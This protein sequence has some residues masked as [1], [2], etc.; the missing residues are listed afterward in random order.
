MWDAKRLCL[1]LLMMICLSARAQFVD[2]FSDGDFTN[3]PEWFGQTDR[4][5]V[6]NGRLRLNAPAVAA[7]SYLTTNSQ[8]IENGVWEFFIRLDFNP[9][10]TNL[11]RVY[12]VADNPDLSQPLNG[13]FVRIGGTE[14]EVSLY[15]QTGSAITKIIDGEDKRIDF[16]LVEVKI[17]VTRDDEGNWELFSDVNASGNY[18]QEGLTIKD[19]THL[20]ST[21][22]G[23]SCIYTQTRSTHFYF[24]DFVVTGTPVTDKFPPEVTQ[25]E[26]VDENSLRII[27]N[28]E[29]EE[30]SATSTANYFLNEGLGIAQ[31]VSLEENNTQALVQFG[32]SFPNGKLLTLSING[33]ED[34]S[35][36]A[37]NNYQNTF[38][39]FVPEPAEWKD[40]IISEFFPDPDPPVGLP[41]QEFVEIYNRSNKVFNLLNWKLIDPGASGT[42][43]ELFFFPGDYLILASN[44]NAPL[45]DSYGQSMGITGMPILSNN[46]DILTLRDPEGNLIDSLSYDLTWYHDNS[47]RDGGWTIE[48]IDIDNFCTD[49]ENYRASADEAGGTP[50]KQNSV[51]DIIIDEAGPKLQQVVISDLNT[52]LLQFDERLSQPSLFAEVE[53]FPERNINERNFTTNIRNEIE[54]VLAEQLMYGNTYQVTVGNV[55]DCKTNSIDPEYGSIEIF[56]EADPPK[57]ISI[58]VLS[59]NELRL[60]FSEELDETSSMATENFI[61]SHNVG[62]PLYAGLSDDN[63]SIDL[64]FESSLINGKTYNII[65]NGVKG[66]FENEIDLIQESFLFFQ[67][68][69]ANKYDIIITELFPDP[70]PPVNLPEHEFVEIYNRSNHPFDLAGWKLV[71][72]GATGTLPAYLMQPG[73]YVILTSLSGVPKFEGFGKALGVPGMPILSNNSDQPSLVSPEG[74]TVDSV[75]YQL[76]WY[77]DNEKRDG[78][79][80]LERIDYENICNDADNWIASADASGGTPGK[81]NS[82]FTVSNN[83]VPPKMQHVLVDSREKINIKFDKKLKQKSLAGDIYIDPSVAINSRS[84]SSA[85]R[86]EIKLDLAE[87]LDWG[88]LYA[89]RVDNMFD[90]YNNTIDSNHAEVEFVALAPAPTI[91]DLI[92]VDANHLKLIFSEELDETSAIVKSNYVV[93][94]EIGEPASILIYQ[95]KTSVELFFLKSFVNGATYNIDISGVMGLYNNEITP[96][97]KS[98]LFFVPVIAKEKDIIITELFPDPTPPVGL[99]EYEFVEI[100]NRSTHPFDLTGWRLVDPGANGRLPSY[101]IQPGE[102]VILASAASSVHYAQYG[103]VLT[104]QNMPIL[105]NAAD[106]VYLVS[107]EGLTID[108]VSYQLSWYRDNEKRD[109]GWTLELIDLNDVC[110]DADNWSSSEDPS[111]GT[112]GR[113]NSINDHRPDLIGPKLLQV[114]AINNMQLLLKFNEKLSDATPNEISIHISENISVSDLHFYD[115]S[116]TQLLLILS[117]TIQPSKKYTIEVADVYDCPGNEI[118]QAYRSATFVLTE[119]AKP[120]DVVINELL[121]NPRPGG[122]DFVEIYNNTEKYFNLKNWQVGNYVNDNPTNLRMITSEDELLAPGAFKIFTSNIDILKGDYPQTK[123]DVAHVVSLPS[124]PDREGTVSLINE[125][126]VLLDYFI[127][128]ENF[129]NPMLK[130]KEGVSLE[131]VSAVTPTNLV[132]NW[133]SAA[134]IAGFAT[135]GYLNSSARAKV[136]IEESSIKIDPEVFIPQY[137][138]EDFTRIIYSFKQAGL[139]A[140]VFVI[141]QQGRKV[142]TI[143]NNELLNQEGFLTWDGSDDSGSRVRPGPYLIFFQLFN[144]TGELQT[145]RKRVVVASRF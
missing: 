132:A 101:L 79:W 118:Q 14:D 77:R 119:E 85:Q 18:I 59:A 27:F 134:S 117:S 111:G 63:K 49:K 124:Y 138:I 52:L 109:G 44:A 56:V 37:M 98:F 123:I 67:P 94:N 13:Y 9:S 74:L 103:N 90:C 19:E 33:V 97:Q 3:N 4:F 8:A 12:L 82:V 75:N 26:I 88:T 73:E 144:T 20:S 41:N 53:I 65:I 42:L 23:V 120:G 110:R 11:A 60:T 131:R 102:Y 83:N 30:I 61:V 55:F 46:G 126:S 141:D 35:G 24:D 58:D 72:P 22:F 130:S 116:K 133:K 84:F 5:I 129:H 48:V 106:Q 36:N 40:I 68:V 96:I 66:L 81:I 86:D 6:D 31:S 1:L 115:Q 140:N 142:R 95:D 136:D 7:T 80:T 92:V 47:K 114:M 105:S 104:V 87:L 69:I 34:L 91:S 107:P 125:S 143:A 39:Y 51:M 29:V 15:R 57:L 127:Y 70:A 38:R 45:F 54:I 2:D 145:I 32:A 139:S 50:G 99:P 113:V 17:K 21:Y 128:H 78:G 93:S 64:I 121:F 10:G 122:V 100:Y 28:E 89:L 71:D 76:T 137:G 112:P 25:I 62:Q 135:P 43:K 108:S 16:N